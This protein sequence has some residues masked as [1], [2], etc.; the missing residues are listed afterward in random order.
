M[1]RCDHCQVDAISN[2]F[3]QPQGWIT[4]FGGDPYR[5]LDFCSWTCQR[6]FALAEVQLAAP[7]AMVVR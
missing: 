1:S 3:T 7:A 2:S 5:H 6:Q 4:V